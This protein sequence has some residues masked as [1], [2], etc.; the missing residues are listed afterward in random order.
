MA[1]C[2]FCEIVAGRVP[3][4]MV[5]ENETC[6]AFID[7][8]QVNPGH[9]LVVP[10][11]HAPA[12]AQLDPEDGAAVFRLAQRVAAALRQSGLRCEGVNLFLS[13]GAAAG[14]EVWHVH[15]HVLP[16][17]Q[18][19]GFGFRLGPHARQPHSRTEL[20]GIASAIRGAMDGQPDSM[21]AYSVDS[22]P[23]ASD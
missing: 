6:C 20:D 13:D 16:R 11:R 2:V 5:A 8:A 9:V 4:S 23:G 18:G 7:I 17:F 10:R 12:L 22:V 14:Q 3:A 15:M 21:G 1:A 19:D